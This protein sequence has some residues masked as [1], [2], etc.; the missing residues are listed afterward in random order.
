LT[1]LLVH[2]ENW[3]GVARLPQLYAA[4][5]ATVHV[6]CAPGSFLAQTRFAAA[7]FDGSAD[8]ATM[9]AL[10]EQHLTANGERYAAVILCDDDVLAA[11]VQRADEAWAGRCLPFAGGAADRALLQRAVSKSAFLDACMSA[12]L[13][14]PASTLCVA[15]DEALGAAGELGYPV[16]VKADRGSGGRA[17]A[18]VDDPAQ[19]ARSYDAFAVAGPVT[20]QRLLRGRVGATDVIFDDGRPLCWSSFY[21][22]RLWPERVGPAAVR[23]YAEPPAIAALARH[24]GELTR[25]HGLAVMCWVEDEADGQPR[26]LELNFRPGP[27]PSHRGPVRAMFAAGLHSLLYGTPY[28]GART[29]GCAGATMNMF[30]Q[31]LHRALGL[32]DV[33]SLAS[34]LPG[35]PSASDVPLDDLPLLRAHVRRVID[36]VL[37]RPV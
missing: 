12:G 6:M 7:V 32:R 2:C 18:I 9:C 8:P 26:L 16:V 3:F 5:G 28:A 4:A 34:W 30:P 10:L 24:V 15:V 25:F 21:K 36:I 35:L 14:I 17:V 27:G 23:R 37:R 19:L 20:I 1:V 31:A 13:P 22:E 33:A 11:L 29:P